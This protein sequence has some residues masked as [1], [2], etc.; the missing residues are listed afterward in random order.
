[1]KLGFV[2]DIHED[3]KRLQT[4]ISVLKA[5]NC[6]KIVCLGDL[7][8]YSVPYFRFLTSRSSSEVIALLRRVCCAIV[9]GNHDLYAIKK[10][11]IHRAS[12]PYP[13]FWYSLDYWKRKE[14]AQD[15]IWLY[16]NEEL[17]A[18]LT[19]EDKDFIANL[20]EFAVDVFDEI[21]VFFSHYAYPDL[22]GA[23]SLDKEQNQIPQH[24][25]FMSTYKCNLGFS[26]HR[27]AEGAVVVTPKSISKLGFGSVQIDRNI[28][29]WIYGPAVANGIY[30]N[31]VMVFDTTTFILQVI[32][33]ND[34]NH[35]LPDWLD[36]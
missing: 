11:P 25:E 9:V 13:E 35:F 27:H 33:L 32:P 8:G 23:T 36:F 4:A 17:S 22:V 7:V 15:K 1:M 16:E 5:C 6:D 30:S 29:T 14:L 20:P 3:I 34:I 2:S 10:L 19:R 12:F 21:N 24:F 18:M 28:P 26:G 31:G